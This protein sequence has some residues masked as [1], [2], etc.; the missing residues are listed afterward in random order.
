[1]L[2][3]SHL[4]VLTTPAHTGSAGQIQPISGNGGQ[5]RPE[6]QQLDWSKAW[7]TSKQDAHGAPTQPLVSG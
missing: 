3:L 4:G 7:P 5:D 6:E 2:P 1:M